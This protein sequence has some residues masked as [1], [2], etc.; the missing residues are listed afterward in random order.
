[1]KL[2][3]YFRLLLKDL[4]FGISDCIILQITKVRGQHLWLMEDEYIMADRGSQRQTVLYAVMCLT[5]TYYND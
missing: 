5:F 2:N 3:Q 4:N 1:M